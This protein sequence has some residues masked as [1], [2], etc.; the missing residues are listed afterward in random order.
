MNVHESLEAREEWMDA[1]GFRAYWAIING[2]PVRDGD[3]SSPAKPSPTTRAI[4]EEARKLASSLPLGIMSSN[5]A[6]ARRVSLVL[7]CPYCGTTSFG[8]G[9]GITYQQAKQP[10]MVKRPTTIDGRLL[11][12]TEKGPVFRAFFVEAGKLVEPGMAAPPM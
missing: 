10:P 2:E 1:P 8:T 9:E 4:L 12:G 3:P 6:G 7:S 5:R 11:T